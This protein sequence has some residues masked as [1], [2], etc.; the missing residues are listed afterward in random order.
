M[1]VRVGASTI[2]FFLDVQLVHPRRVHVYYTC[3]C[4][5]GTDC[6]PGLYLHA[7]DGL[8]IRWLRRQDVSG[9]E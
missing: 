4:T 1:Q 9:A 7:G 2:Q 3:T 8:M 5:P 6:I